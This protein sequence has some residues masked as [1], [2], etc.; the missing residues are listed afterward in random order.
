MWWKVSPSRKELLAQLTQLTEQ[1]SEVTEKLQKQTMNVTVQSLH[2]DHATLERL[3]FRLDSLDIHDLSGSL[4]L[5]NN[6]QQPPL[7]SNHSQHQVHLGSP[8]QDDT[9][10]VSK[11]AI[12]K[13]PISTPEQTEGILTTNRGYAIRFP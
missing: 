5:G 7:H 1:M 2:V 12:S 3:V 11:T 8:V 6:F 13:Q 4:N 10:R 9:G